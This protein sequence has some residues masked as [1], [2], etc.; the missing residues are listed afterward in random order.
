M[1]PHACRT[2][3][4]EEDLAPVLET[5]NARRPSDRPALDFSVGWKQKGPQAK[6]AEKGSGESEEVAEPVHKSRHL[7]KFKACGKR[8]FGLL[9]VRRATPALDF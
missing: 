8:C 3:H 6:I 5:I 7:G 2:S 4:I 1:V 9:H